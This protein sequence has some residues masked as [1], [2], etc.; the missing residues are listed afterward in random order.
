MS[1]NFNRRLKLF[2]WSDSLTKIFLE[3]EPDLIQPI[4]IFH[5]WDRKSL[6]ARLLL[7]PW[8]PFEHNI[9]LRLL[10]KKAP[11]AKRQILG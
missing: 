2:D 9:Y 6:L 3:G 10:S 8:R 1:R 11:R 4:R 5:P 7:A